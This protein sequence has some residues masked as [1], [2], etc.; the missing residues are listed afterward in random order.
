MFRVVIRF[1]ISFRTLRNLYLNKTIINSYKDT[2]ISQC[3]KIVQKKKKK[4]TGR[5][6]E[7]WQ[8]FEK[9]WKLVKLQYD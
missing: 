9:V 8:L 7:K 3:K 5:E 4:K 6:K 2:K 1:F